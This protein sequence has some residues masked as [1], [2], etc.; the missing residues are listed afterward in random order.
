MDDQM[1]IRIQRAINNIP[2][3]MI[4]QNGREAIYF[5][6]SGESD[7]C[8][9]LGII[10]DFHVISYEPYTIIKQY[11]DLEVLHKEDVTQIVFRSESAK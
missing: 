2:K 1:Q 11:R 9:Y 5:L 4:E 7:K 3:E 6:R 10:D 8:Y